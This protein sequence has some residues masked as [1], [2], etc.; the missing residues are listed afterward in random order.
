MPST[1]DSGSSK[2]RYLAAIPWIGPILDATL[3]PQSP[4][5]IGAASDPLLGRALAAALV[6]VVRDDLRERF[7]PRNPH[8]EPLGWVT[9]LDSDSNGRF[10]V[11]LPDML[12]EGGV[13]GVLMVLLY[14]H[15][16][17]SL[18]QAFAVRWD[19]ISALPPDPRD[20]IRRQVLKLLLRP[21]KDL[22]PGLIERCDAQASELTFAVASCKYPAGFLDGGPAEASYGRL[23]GRLDITGKTGWPKCLLLLGDQVYLDAT[24]GLFDPKGRYDRYDLPYERLLRTEPLRHILRRIP[25]YMML[26][27]HEIADNWEPVDGDNGSDAD[28]VEGR[29]AY[30][31]Y[32]RMAGP[33]ELPPFSDSREP[34]WYSFTVDG[35]PFFMADTRTERLPRSA[36]GIEDA[37]IM[38][39]SQFTK[40]LAWLERAQEHQGDTPKF[41]A[42]PASFLPRHRRAVQHGHPASALR[43]DGWDGYPASFFDLLTRIVTKKIDN[44][45]FL[46]GDEHVSFVAHADITDKASR[47]VARIHSIHSSGLYSPFPFANSVEESLCCDDEFEFGNYRCKV[48]TPNVTPGDGF[49]LLQVSGKR[50]A[51]SVRCCFNRA[52][53]SNVGGTWIDV[54]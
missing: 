27:D 50:G 42:S 36:Q 4:I 22:E 43:S 3:V 48:V 6:P 49:A 53:G 38:R 46:S 44:V 33:E 20:E 47:K 25:V 19:A 37:R 30:I 40:L 8:G 13:A 11:E 32:Q 2:P 23:A 31:E 15:S 17:A 5:R 12:W 16:A 41:I 39:P 21:I 10:R 7:A 54:L 28:L 1:G 52:P 29:R 45:I 9:T 26:D 14:N 24:A 51:W 35:F 18:E 34:L